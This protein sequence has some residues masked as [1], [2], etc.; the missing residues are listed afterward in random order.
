MNMSES[1]KELAAALSAAQGEMPAVPMGSVNP[2]LKNKYANLGDVIKTAQP[3][4]ARHGLSYSQSV[5]TDGPTIGIETILMHSSGEWLMSKM[6]IHP[7]EDKGISSAQSAGKTITY[8]RRYTLSAMLGV[9]AD[10]DADGNAE[11]QKTTQASKPQVAPAPAPA[12]P[13]EMTLEEAMTVKTKDGKSYGDVSS[14]HLALIANNTAVPAL[15]RAAAGAILNARAK[16]A[17]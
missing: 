16:S 1:I 14:D 6:A 11:T 3:V 17:Q 15:N 5:F 13:V 4:L 8:L 9:Y 2:F 7:G 10:E 12:A